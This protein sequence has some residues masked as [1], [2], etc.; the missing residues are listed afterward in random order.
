MTGLRD[1]LARVGI[2]GR[3][4]RRI[5]LELEDHA[6]CDPEANLGAPREIAERFAVE[7]R[8]PRTR[9]SAYGGFA[10]LALTAVLL[11]VPSRGVSAAGGWPDS[12][13]GRGLVVSLGGLTIVLAGQVA[14][15]TGILALWRV[16][17]R[18]A[19]V[20]EL[21]LVQ[22]RLGIALAA[23][24]VV[25]A[26]QAVQAAALQPLLPTWWFALAIPAVFVPGL[27]LGGAAYG[28][29]E[30]VAITPS[31][32]P[33]P[34]GFPMPLVLA[35]GVGAVVLIAVGS[36]FTEHSLAEGLSR[37]V[38]EAVAFAA[39]FVVLGRRLGIRR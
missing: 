21:R 30:A 1:E 20:E 23:G 18:P 39:C 13:G 7:L 8:V 28:L 11:G 32:D 2:R 29:R 26:G 15:V 5:V 27:A 31:V 36:T 4:A 17:R 34:R 24:G 16:L 22:R 9:R 37:G 38:L 10:A 6:R 14:F 25:L 3:L 19:A 35:I 33:A 12:I